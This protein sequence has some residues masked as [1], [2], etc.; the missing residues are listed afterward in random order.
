MMQQLGGYADAI[1]LVAVGFLASVHPV[2]FVGRTRQD[3]RR[4]KLVRMAGV[5]L[6]GIGLGLLTL[7]LS[8]A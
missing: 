8:G 3:G 5:L 1:L 7:R 2:L 6:L 4:K